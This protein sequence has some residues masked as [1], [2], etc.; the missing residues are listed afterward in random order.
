M[1]FI[2][3]ITIEDALKE[4]SMLDSLK[5]IQAATNIPVKVIKSNS[6]F[7][8]E[9]ICTYFNE[10]VA[11]EKFPNCLKLANITPVFEKGAGTPKNNDRPKSI[12]P[13]FS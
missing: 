13:V 9:Q 3:T 12:L 1:F 4:I 7:L 11:K 5:A 8:S 2:N 6:N 10:S